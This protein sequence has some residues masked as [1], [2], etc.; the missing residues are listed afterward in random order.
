MENK[1][2]RPKNIKLKNGIISY[3][4][5]GEGYPIICIP[6]WM[7]TSIIYYPLSKLLDKKLKLICIDLPSWGER[8]KLFNKEVNIDSYISLT[9]EFIKK[10][11]LPSFSLLGY[12]YGGVIAQ[13]LIAEE[14][15][16]PDKLILISTLNGGLQTFGLNRYKILLNGANK[17]KG[18]ITNERV[19]KQ[20][21]IFTTKMHIAFSYPK[22]E[23]NLKFI[24]TIIEDIG[25]ISIID[26]LEAVNSLYGRTFLT[27]RLKKTSTLLI[28]GEDERTYIKKGMHDIS[29][30]L[31]IKTEVIPNVNH[32]HL[33]FK[34]EESKLLLDKFLES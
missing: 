15:I 20:L 17:M 26:G 32:H 10:L 29:K 30:Y 11:D 4:E 19:L 25:N 23:D 5:Y 2:P 33:V 3:R 22:R 13:G 14:D 9:R 18:L 28:R 6:P 7:T 27:S 8:S 12:S 34:P 21:Y 24:E 31:G 1:I 16:K